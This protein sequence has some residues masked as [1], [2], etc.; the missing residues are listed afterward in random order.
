MQEPLTPNHL[1][2]SLNP[3]PFQNTPKSGPV[4]MHLQS[5]EPFPEDKW[6]GHKAHV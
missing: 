3:I 5:L 1:G 2:T 6:M 4:G